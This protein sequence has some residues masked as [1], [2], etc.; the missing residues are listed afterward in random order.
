M[1]RY[2]AAAML[3]T[4]SGCVAD[5]G[6]DGSGGEAGAPTDGN[7]GSGGHGDGAGGMAGAGG[8]GGDG[9]RWPIQCADAS[10]C[11]VDADPADCRFIECNAGTCI[12]RTSLFGDACG[13]RSSPGVCDHGVC[14]PTDGP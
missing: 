13:T 9:G 1:Y 4:A 3:Y 2:V 5:G 6:S 14:I 11:P 7:G 12:S 8:S 10:D